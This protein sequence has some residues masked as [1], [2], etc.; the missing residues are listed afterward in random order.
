[1]AGLP[2]LCVGVTGRAG[3][4]KSTLCALWE[5]RGARRIDADAVGRALLQRDTPVFKRVVEA[6]GP[7][8]LGPAGDI[9]RQSL[10]ARVFA[11]SR[12]R[13]RLNSL[14]HPP[15]LLQLHAELAQF[16]REP[17]ASR[18]LILDAA[19][20]VEWGDRSLWD[21][22]VLV[23]APH[24]LQIERLTKARGF[25]AP[26]AEAILRAQLPDEARRAL[27]DEEVVND[28]DLAHLQAEAGRL[29]D[30]WQRLLN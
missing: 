4:G 25:T 23:C 26:D 8:I 15:L 29:W 27:A 17:P 9:D 6:F 16:R 7:G 1:M 3:S 14:V 21:R 2:S 28:G 13:E 24:A 18:I 10:G 11:D 5:A 19:L 20:L 22:L 30:A 12:E